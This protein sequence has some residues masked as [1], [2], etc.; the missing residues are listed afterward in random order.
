[1]TTITRA[2]IAAGLLAF[3]L[4]SPASAQ[5]NTLP[6]HRIIAV[7]G[8]GYVSAAPDTARI[9]AGVTAKA[10][11]PDAAL[12]KTSAIIAK[13]IGKLK[14]L[15]VDEKDIQT[16]LVSVQKYTADHAS[17][18][19]AANTLTITVRDLNKLGAL[20]SAVTAEGANEVSANSHSYSIDA[21]EKLRSIARAQA[22][23]NARQK[24]QEIAK[25]MGAELDEAKVVID[26]PAMLPGKSQGE[27]GLPILGEVYRSF[28]GNAAPV[29]RGTNSVPVK[30]Y[31]WWSVR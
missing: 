20:L 21:P 22:F 15:G 5:Q 31:V 4:I 1:M 8:V 19:T 26:D 11:T 10:P 25:S 2:L 29:E 23:E 27:D 18:Y 12:S 28:G 6:Q 17:G 13:V 30:L 3:A 14:E 16:A 24:A 9:Q 7:S